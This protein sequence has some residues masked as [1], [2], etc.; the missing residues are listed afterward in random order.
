MVG[1]KEVF[2]GVVTLEN[3]EGTKERAEQRRSREQGGEH[4]E[5]RCGMSTGAGVG[6]LEKRLVQNGQETCSLFCHVCHE[7]PISNASL[8][9]Y[10]RRLKWT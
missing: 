8:K 6:R 1:G 3:P 4:P 7:S 9:V 10:Y 5:G 2:S